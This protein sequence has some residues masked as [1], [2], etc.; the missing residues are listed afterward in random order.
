[1]GKG[2]DFSHRFR[3]KKLSAASGNF[4]AMVNVFARLLLGQRINMVAYRYSL[5]DGFIAFL[6]QHLVE[7]ALTD[8]KDVDQF[9]VV[10]LNV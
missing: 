6:I 2:I 1:V 9:A 4:E 8:K 10:Q 5:S 3:F 7:F